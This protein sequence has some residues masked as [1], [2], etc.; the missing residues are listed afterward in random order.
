MARFGD[1]G[2]RYTNKDGSILTDGVIDFFDSGTN[3]VKPTFADIDETP[4]LQ[5]PS[6]LVL[7]A[8]GSQPNCFFSGSAKAVLRSLSKGQIDSLDPVTASASEGGRLAFASYNALSTYSNP[9]LVTASD[10]LYYRCIVATSQGQEPSATPADWT[11]QLFVQVYNALQTYLVN[12]IV[13][14]SN[15]SL[16]KALV[17]QLG[18]NPLT[19][20]TNWREVGS[21]KYD[22]AVNYFLGDIAQDTDN[23]YYISISDTNINN[24]PSST[25]TKW[26]LIRWIKTYNANEDY[27]IGAVVQET[28]GLM[29]RGL[30]TPNVG[31]TPNSSPSDWAAVVSTTVGNDV[32]TF[33]S[34]G[35]WTKP[36]TGTYALIENI[37]AGAGGENRTGGVDAF[38]GGGGAYNSIV[39]LL[40]ALGAT[41]TVTIPAGG[42]GGA[43]AG[44]NI[45]ADGGDTTFGAHL[46]ATGGVGLNGRSGDQVIGTTGQAPGSFS[47]GSG[48]D[49][50]TG[51]GGPAGQGGAGGGG[52]GAAADEAGGT[53]Q[54]GGDG[55]DGVFTA[56]TPGQDGSAGGG[57]GGGSSNDGGGGDGGDGRCKVTV[58]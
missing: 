52:S 40:S 23:E 25:A 56:A 14:A 4:A 57:G 30:T 22:V 8:D 7:N 27:A 33:T 39:L 20:E 53:S 44:N 48:A 10:G 2:T 29:W 58:W 55:G 47:S 19:D 18:N 51:I 11:Q 42:L 26:T 9:D 12:D 21:H 38:G 32:Q 28:T 5:N 15:G 17:S 35:T 16:Y 54:N 13:E 3:D 34:S 50:A 1:L 37:A 31:N 6:P 36:G 49:G 24:D 45:G 43:D 41:E 46:T